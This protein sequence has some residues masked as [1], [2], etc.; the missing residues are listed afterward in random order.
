M[1]RHEG[2]EIAPG[3]VFE[4][5]ESKE[6]LC[7]VVLSV[8]DGRF[9]ALSERNREVSLTLSRMVHHG[10]T[11]LDLKLGRDELLQKLASISEIRKGIM[12]RVDL[13][14]IWS[15]LESEE[16]GYDAEEIAEFIFSTPISDDQAAA[17]KRMLLSDRLYF[18]AKDSGFYARSAENVDA[19]RLELQKEV[20]RELR[21]AEG[22]RWLGAI[23]SRKQ[24]VPQ[25]E[26]REEL[27]KEL[28]N[29]ALFGQEAKESAFVKELLKL[30]AVPPT[31]QTAF[32]ILVR[33]GVWREDENLLLHEHGISSE[34]PPEAMQQAE[35]IIKSSCA[36]AAGNEREDLTGLD[37]FTVDSPL[38]R[39]YDD[40]LSVRE[41]EHGLLE[42]GIHIA[43]AA[44]LVLQGTPLDRE[45][46]A[47]ASSIYLPDERV[48]ML[49]HSLSEGILSLKEGEDR[50][51]L[52]F[53]ITIDSEADISETRICQSV[54][55]I[56]RQLTYRDANESIDKDSRLKALYELALKLR[57]KRLELGAVILPLPEIQVYV[58]SAGMIQIAH[59]DKE[60]PSQILVSEWMIEANAAAAGYL[61][62]RHIPALYRSQAECRPETE[63]VQSEHELF[64]AYR[65]RRLF[66][67]AE[68]ATEPKPHCSLAI[69]HY[70]TVTS[71][72]RRYSDLVVQRQLKHTL[73]TGSGLYSKQQLDE[74]TGQLSA[75][76]A[77][78]FTIQRKCTRYWILKYLE[79][80]DIEN[81]NAL[82]LDKNARYAH[83]LIPDFLLEANAPVPE[84][85][86]F[87]Q[88]DMVKIHIEK[89]LPREDVLKIQI[90]DT[91]PR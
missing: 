10:K 61:A 66:S 14:Q 19:R 87:N 48:S 80:E 41:L 90:L 78:V 37:V 11:S 51:A 63:F 72:I 18:Q 43:D 60:S 22:A 12:G 36:A 69:A 38:T 33:L 58:N 59:Y 8:K 57:R 25:I 32:R 30:A 89:A 74:L 1:S 75:A 70:T 42:V 26:F 21:L 54:V 81:L 28:K 5:Y 23:H 49:P 50:L 76:Q 3:A 6:I 73:A 40:A 47:R 71:P 55:R 56:R 31:P 86:K 82:V 53:L 52:S 24:S 17:V 16:A 67:R 83:L 13:E 2:L 91:P 35:V 64:K 85:A 84:N 20:Q 62:Q 34:F 44:E 29:F 7:G 27:I 77:L 68:L 65:Q 9:N 15:L 88:G 39:D 79:Q 45:A 46:E 4:F